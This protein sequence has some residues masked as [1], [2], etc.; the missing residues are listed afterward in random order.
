MAAA[1]GDKA[2]IDALVFGE[3]QLL[4]AEKRTALATLR[5]GI[6]VSALPMTVLSF[7]IATSRHYEAGH[8]LQLLIPVMVF[9]VALMGLGVYLIGHSVRRVRRYDQLIRTLKQQHSLVA[10]FL[11]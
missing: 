8:V 2:G 4:L 9:N 7:L 11:D 1:D 10:P 5:S 6:A 3:I